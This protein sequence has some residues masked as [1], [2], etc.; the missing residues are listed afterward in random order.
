M[1]HLYS[2]SDDLSLPQPTN[3]LPEAASL[4]GMCLL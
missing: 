3:G 2:I 4:S 1:N